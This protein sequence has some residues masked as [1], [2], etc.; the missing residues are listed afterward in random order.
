MTQRFG[1]W[2]SVQGSLGYREAWLKRDEALV[3]FNDYSSAHARAEELNK[4]KMKN[5]HAIFY[6]CPRL[7]G[8]S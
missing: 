4:E 1:I 6:Y 8:E 5:P 3:E 7:I 2:C